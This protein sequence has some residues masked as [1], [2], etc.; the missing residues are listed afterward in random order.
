MFAVG[1]GCVAC[2]CNGDVGE[3][4]GDV[5]VAAFDQ[6]TECLTESVL[7]CRDN[8]ALTFQSCGCAEGCGKRK[9]LALV[10]GA[11]PV[12]GLT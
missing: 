8:G 6:G 10:H 12:T 1:G 9:L 3:V 7:E 4:G 5:D 11:E 2:S